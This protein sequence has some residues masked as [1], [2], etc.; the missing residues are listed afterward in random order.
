MKKTMID[1]LDKIGRDKFLVIAPFTSL[2]ADIILIY[3]ATSVLLP[4]MF[5]REYIMKYIK[6]IHGPQAHLPF[7][8]LQVMLGVTKT[9]T[10]ILLFGFFLFNCVIA[11][12]VY[13]KSPN[14]IKYLLGYTGSTA[15]ISIFELFGFYYN[16]NK[17]N[18]YTFITMILYGFVFFGLRYFKEKPVIEPGTKTEAQ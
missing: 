6:M 1:I 12:N 7:D 15:F 10:S 18:Y 13:K 5:S 2:F 8:A 11:Y 3:Y 9:G 16:M 4:M 17:F 14:S